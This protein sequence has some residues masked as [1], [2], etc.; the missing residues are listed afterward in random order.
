MHHVNAD[1]VSN[2]AGLARSGKHL[3][4]I[5]LLYYCVEGGRFTI[6]VFLGHKP[7]YRLDLESG[8]KTLCILPFQ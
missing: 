7:L 2:L 3:R 1:T 5:C 8:A 4:K 6:H